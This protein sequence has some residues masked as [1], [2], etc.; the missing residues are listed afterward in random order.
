MTSASAGSIGAQGGLNGK[1]VPGKPG[2][3]AN[4]RGLL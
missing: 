4:A 3:G 1:G 2:P